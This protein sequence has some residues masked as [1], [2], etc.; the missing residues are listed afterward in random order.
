MGFRGRTAEPKLKEVSLI[1]ILVMGSK[2]K[3]PHFV[4]EMGMIEPILQGLCEN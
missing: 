3:R 4:C 2:D 1:L